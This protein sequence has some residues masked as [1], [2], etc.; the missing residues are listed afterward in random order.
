MTASI[1][2]TIG[3]MG[4]A[5]I[6]VPVVLVGLQFLVDGNVLAG[7]GF[8]AIAALMVG[9]SEYIKTPTDVPGSTAQRVAGWIAKPPDEEE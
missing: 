7:T 2:E 8:L 3:R 4:T 5:L 1:V 6:T 9:I